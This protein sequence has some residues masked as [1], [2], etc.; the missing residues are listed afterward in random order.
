MA[1]EYRHPYGYGTYH[2]HHADGECWVIH[3]PPGG[4]EW[5]SRHRDVAQPVDAGAAYIHA[6]EL[7]RD[8]DVCRQMGLDDAAVR[9]DPGTSPQ[10]RNLAD[11]A[12]Q[13]SFRF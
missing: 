13:S 3:V 4:S 8:L 11:V 10:E 1:R 12:R 7:N 6:E 9:C 2:I 5:S